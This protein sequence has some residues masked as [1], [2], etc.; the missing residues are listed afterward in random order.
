V[1][2]AL[3]VEPTGAEPLVR[4]TKYGK[5]CT[6]FVRKPAGGGE[7]EG[8]GNTRVSANSSCRRFK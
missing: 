2:L 6:G 1:N 8:G 4:P 7:M 5:N 3:G